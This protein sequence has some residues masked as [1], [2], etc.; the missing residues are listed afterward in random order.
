MTYY[1]LLSGGSGRRLWP[2][3]SEARPKQYLKLVNRETNSMERCSM[4]QR[5]WDQLTEAEMAEY[6]VITAGESQAELIQSQVPGARI[7][8]EPSG[9]DTFG[10]VLLS[11]AYLYS[12]L[13]AAREDYAVIMPVDPYTEGL[14]FETVKGLADVVK[15][16]GM[17]I[18][19]LG[20]VPSY[21][22]TKY[23]YILP[24]ERKEDYFKAEGFVEKPDESRAGEL[25]RRGA[26]WNC[27][28][29]CVR[30]GSM[31][32][33][34]AAYGVPEDYEGLCRSY[35]KLPAASFDY[36]VLEKTEKL[37]VVEFRGFWKDLGTW[38]AMADQ[39]ST[40]T[41]GRAVLSDTC[42]NTQI[43]NELKAPVTAVGTRDLVIAAGP[44]G[45]LVADKG[46]ASKVKELTADFQMRPMFE[47]RRWGTLETLDDTKGPEVST[48]TRKIRIYDGMASS[49]HYHQNRDEIW[50]ILKGTGEL[51]LEGNKIPLSPGKAV[52]IR[53][54]QRHAVKAFRDFEY[55]EIH[56]GCSVGN[57]DIHRI[58]FEWDEIE[59]AHIL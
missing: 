58:T 23:G 5:V 29:F 9:R 24:G 33:H 38:D 41:V 49:Y 43:I 47:E 20:A 36:E 18:G 57:A 1:A 11:C 16:S 53:K 45:I 31:L 3:S 22:A 56:V 7:A 51:I 6:T 30:I 34:A 17:E 12:R 15:R 21:P 35:E 42:R 25:I 4:L 8:A 39:M 19:L 48:L 37:A 13:G 54:N 59:L 52:C 50:T 32:D 27:G 55:I 26:L 46:E 28:V 40:D 10:A 44:D 2:L 14:Y